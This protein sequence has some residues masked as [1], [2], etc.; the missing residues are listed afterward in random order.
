MMDFF[1]KS[2]NPFMSMMHMDPED[3]ADGADM[4]PMMFMPQMF[5]PQMLM[6]QMQLMHAMFMMPFSMMKSMA[7]MMQGQAAGSD[8]E[9]A[10]EEPAK[11]GIKIGG[12]DVPPELI[13]KLL[14]TDMSPEGLEKL[15]KVLDVVL[16][17]MPG[18][19]KKTHGQED[20]DE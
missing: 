6:M 1:G 4:N 17:A 11:T 20:K 8:A 12:F 5:M 19:K 16:G 3:A 7:A 18:E 13:Q 2:Q 15:Q 14:Y 10:A 9:K